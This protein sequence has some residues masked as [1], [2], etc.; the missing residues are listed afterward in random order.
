[1]TQSMWW[2]DLVTKTNTP[3]AWHEGKRPQ[4][5]S[6]VHL[7][8]SIHERY[9]PSAAAETFR[10]EIFYG[11]QQT[12]GEPHVGFIGRVI[13]LVDAAKER[14]MEMWT[15]RDRNL[16]AELC[17]RGSSSL[18]R[19]TRWTANIHPATGQSTANS[20]ECVAAARFWPKPG[21]SGRRARRPARTA[22]AGSQGEE[23]LPRWPPPPS[24]AAT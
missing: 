10:E 2:R 24:S 8:N 22:A 20:T 7:W 12:R 9:F 17:A 4:A 15:K 5:G 11:V 19:P 23:Q 13:D 21:P 3:R 18:T 6:L 14:R 1:M 16:A